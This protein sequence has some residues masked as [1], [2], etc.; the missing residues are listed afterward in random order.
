LDSLIVDQKDG[1]ATVVFNDPVHHN[2][3]SYH[4]WLELERIATHLEH[5]D[6]I[7]VVVFT[8]AGDRDFCTGGNIED[9]DLHR[10]NSNQARTYATACDA[11]LDALE[12][13]TKPTIS[14][15]KGYCVGGGCALAMAT[16][17]RVASDASGFSI[18]AGK[19]GILLSYG[20]MR[21]LVNL[22]GHGNARYILLTARLMD[23]QEAL[24]IGLVNAVVPQEVIEDYTYQLAKDMAG[25]APLSQRG[26]KHMLQIARRN[27]LLTGL[28]PAEENLPF[29]CF[30]TED[31]VEGRRAF[32]EGRP[33]QFNGVKPS[34]AAPRQSQ[35]A[36][37]AQLAQATDRFIEFKREDVEQSIPA[38]FEQ[39]I[40]MHPDRI[41]V[42]TRTTE[43]T[44]EALNKAANRVA[45][46]IVAQVETEDKPVALLFE[47]GSEAI[48]AL[49][50][51][52]KTGKIYV[53]LD[54]SLPRPR[55]SYMLEDSQANVMVTNTQHV[56]LARQLAGD[57]CRLLNIDALD[58]SLSV[59]NLDLSISPDTLAVILYT[60]GSTGQPKGVIHSHRNVM[61][62]IM[63][64]TNIFG[65][66]A[67]DRFSLLFP[68]S[69]N[70][71]LRD[72]FGALLNGA[73]VFPADMKTEWV[74]NVGGWLM[75]EGITIWGTAPTIFRHVTSTLT[76]E[77]GLPHLRL[78]VLGGER[79]RA[80]DIALYKQCF[81][82][83]CVLI[84]RLGSTETGNLRFYPVD[85]Q[86]QIDG[87]IVPVGYEV[88]GNE[89]LL[90][91]DDGN[92]VGCDQ[93]GEIVVKSRY[94]SRGYWRKPDLTRAAFSPV[95]GDGDKRLYHTGDLGIMRRDGCL[96]HLGRKDLVVKIRGNRVDVSE[97]ETQLLELD[98]VKE[99][100]VTPYE[101]QDG[102]PRLVAYVVPTEGSEPTTGAMMRRSLTRS[103][104]HYMIPSAFVVLDKLPLTPNG[105]VDLRAL[106]APEV[107]RPELE[108]TFIPP[109]TQT[110]RI[111][112]DLWVKELKINKLGVQDNFF[113]L[114]GQSLTAMRLISEIRHVFH[115]E[116]PLQHFFDAP[117]VAELARI[118]EQRKLNQID[119]EA[120]DVLL[121][122]LDQMSEDEAKALL[123]KK[124]QEAGLL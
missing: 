63:T 22:V 57:G 36:I 54:P 84:S 117:T 76:G 41:A 89:I 91:D 69:V 64:Y 31:Y 121:R 74:G 6:D 100:V 52:L 73:T 58:A 105:K 10:S 17:V 33:P 97:I 27:P 90:L 119:S 70:A 21:R 111:L 68:W 108:H 43:L 47:Q 8:G 12:A 88:E 35:R 82:Q 18:P 56:V 79:T 49:M 85:K 60:S 110:E 112:V 62:L 9:F 11:A 25:L 77:E 71:A 28:T 19:L 81:S 106:P 20:E 15:I 44:Y 32:L 102:E 95:P 96:V 66:C 38:R 93:P 61:H 50:G 30:D 40:R 72:I 107:N 75:H 113:E 67:D 13:L 39:Q 23:A 104:P 46:A 94:L 115:V 123:A 86:T 114:G 7:K 122:K 103:L 29:T 101:G 116:I 3:M 42:K 87:D 53:P 98:A 34:A 5:E 51:V 48:A 92:D 78:I 124:K 4:G 24:R 37:L 59:E 14:M 1:I 80:A 118:I 65:I 99:V 120:L 26:H 16:D 45:R 55:L 109:R 2:A 83:D